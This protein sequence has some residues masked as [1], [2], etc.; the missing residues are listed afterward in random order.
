MKSD[1]NPQER[2]EQEAGSD[3]E[4]SRALQASA[5]PYVP[6]LVSG[7]RA[8]LILLQEVTLPQLRALRHFSGERQYT[9]ATAPTGERV[10]VSDWYPNARILRVLLEKQLLTGSR[11]TRAPRAI[12]PPRCRYELSE[13][14]KAIV[15]AERGYAVRQY[16]SG[17]WI[18][19][20]ASAKA[21]NKAKAD[22]L[23][24]RRLRFTSVRW[25]EP[26]GTCAAEFTWACKPSG[27]YGWV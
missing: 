21:V 23:K 4:T 17:D 27:D 13:A 11:A 16:G 12:Q 20:C 24:D 14:G 3:P 9:S 8:Q 26:Q 7:S 5:G 1:R 22:K 19:V 6:R 2:H 10:L 15:D 18:A 25:A